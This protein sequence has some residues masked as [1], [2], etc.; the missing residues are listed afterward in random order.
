MPY[1]PILDLG[2]IE[3]DLRY[4]QNDVRGISIT[5]TDKVSGL[6]KDLT[7]YVFTAGIISP[8]VSFTCTNSAPLTGVMTINISAEN[9]ST[10]VKGGKYRWYVTY[11]FQ[12]VTRKNIEGDFILV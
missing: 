12:G 7:N 4:S 8:A 3:Q 1:A 5:Y 2:Y 11:V 6:P 9:T 10:L